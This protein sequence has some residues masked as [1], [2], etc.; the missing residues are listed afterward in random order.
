MASSQH[1]RLPFPLHRTALF[2]G[3]KWVGGPSPWGCT[4]VLPVLVA[5]DE[6]PAQQRCSACCVQN[7]PSVFVGNATFQPSRLR[8]VDV[9]SGWRRHRGPGRGLHGQRT[10]HRRELPSAHRSIG[11]SLRFVLRGGDDKWIEADNHTHRRPPRGLPTSLGVW[12]QGMPGPG[13]PLGRSG[14]TNLDICVTAH[15]S[16]ARACAHT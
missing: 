11:L 10:K 2:W 5:H 12:E 7:H 13:F 6:L 16:R 1:A 3:R 9:P 15:S 8:R 14:Q 4:S